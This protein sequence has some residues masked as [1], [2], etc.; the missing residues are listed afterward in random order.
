MRKLNVPG[1]RTGF[2]NSRGGE[3]DGD[4]QEG[5]CL[6]ARQAN[7]I[8][9][10]ERQ[11]ALAVQVIAPGHDGALCLKGQAVGA[12]ADH[13]HHVAESRRH[14]DLALGIVT[15]RHH[16]PIAPHRQAVVF[17]GSNGHHTRQA[18]GHNQTVRRRSRRHRV[19]SP[20]HHRA[21]GPQRQTVIAPGGNCQ[22]VAQPNRA[23]CSVPNCCHPRPSRSHRGA[24]PGCARCRR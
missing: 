20:S 11:V 15:P 21:V 9:Q 16:C 3:S 4:E 24:G 8:R 23:R 13:R 1:V 6:A 7:D 22:H 10:G 18:H 12:A 5:V 2:S 17:T 19:F 14:A